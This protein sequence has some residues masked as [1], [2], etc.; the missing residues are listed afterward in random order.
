MGKLSIK[1]LKK[2]YGLLIIGIF[3]FTCMAV[4]SAGSKTSA[5][6]GETGY[7]MVKG[8]D[9]NYLTTDE[10]RFS[11]TK[12]TKFYNQD[13]EEINSNNILISSMVSVV[14]RRTGGELAAV[15]IMLQ[16]PPKE[17]LPE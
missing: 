2:I 17:R 4:A 13:G 5:P 3:T 12:Q 16:T 9:K 1:S 14:Y 6:E 8:I 15:E 11:I 7:V 10:D